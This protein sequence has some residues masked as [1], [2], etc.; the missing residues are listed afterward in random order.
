MATQNPSTSASQTRLEKNVAISLWLLSGVFVAVMLVTTS[1]AIENRLPE[2]A[3]QSDT[4]FGSDVNRHVDWVLR[5]VPGRAHLHPLSFA[6]FWAT[7]HLFRLAHIP[8]QAHP[9]VLSALPVLL[10]F[11]V[12]IAP[13]AFSLAGVSD[14]SGRKRLWQSAIYLV[15][16]V[17]IG[18]CFTYACVPESH[19]LG[20]LCL[21]AE[22]AFV[23]S[24]LRRRARDGERKNAH[25][26]R[27]AILFG[28]AAMGFTLTNLFLATVLLVPILRR[29][30]VP[31]ILLAV[32]TVFALEAGLVAMYGTAALT[33]T[34]DGLRAGT[35]VEASY[36]RVPDV[37][38]F[39]LALS[40]VFFVQFGTP[41]T[42]IARIHDQTQNSSSP[43]GA[44]GIFLAGAT[45]GQITACALWFAGIAKHLFHRR[46][47]IW[48]ERLVAV[49]CLAS[50][51]L[52]LIFHASYDVTECYIFS[53]D[54]WPVLVVP[55]ILCATDAWR[56]REWTVVSVLLIAVALST[57]QTV[58]A[59]PHLLTL[60]KHSLA[61]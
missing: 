15:A 18:P 11:A 27:I 28:A 43:P 29:K 10:A 13:V 9:V 61:P 46:A 16:I 52:L 26:A 4:W 31:W 34:G 51:P 45:L 7:S 1:L 12:A 53:P 54:V 5:C 57:V 50:L 24:E 49:A 48:N 30:L 33:G 47:E 8:V 39:A 14:I 21:F 23:V 35:A 6:V 2:I 20:G 25:L 22:A 19:V 56:R 44:L 42:D 59:V 38:A 40:H 32:G 60:L 41:N 37:H 17:V 36:L 55:G 58:F 3:T